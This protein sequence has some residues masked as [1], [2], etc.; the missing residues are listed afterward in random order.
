MIPVAKQIL[1]IRHGE[2]AWSLEGKY[3]G[4][5]D[6]ALNANGKKQA[7]ELAPKLKCFEVDKVYTSDLKRAVEFA[8]IVFEK[9]VAEKLG[10]IREMNFGIFEGL[11]YSEVIH[12]H[13]EIY[14]QWLKDPFHGAIPGGESLPE[15]ATRVREALKKKMLASPGQTI[16]IVT[17]AG[18]MKVILCELMH[19]DLEKEIWRLQPAVASTY[20]LD[21]RNGK[22]RARI[23]GE[24]GWIPWEN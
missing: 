23:L 3:C 13:A 4:H 9:V 19:L 2:T 22:A 14:S 24:A 8:G 17:H 18:P 1:L 16:G 6:I 20:A 12:A 10:A 15:M 11:R 7:R 5:T 21:L